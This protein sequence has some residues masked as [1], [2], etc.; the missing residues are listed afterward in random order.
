M[1]AA[2]RAVAAPMNAGLLMLR[3]RAGLQRSSRGAQG[4]TGGGEL[5]AR[6]QVAFDLYISRTLRSRHDDRRIRLANVRLVTRVGQR[7][8]RHK[9]DGR[10]HDDH[11]QRQALDQLS[12][13]SHAVRLLSLPTEG[14]CVMD[15]NIEQGRRSVMTCR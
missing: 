3:I 15:Y 6:D 2:R 8:C 5:G 11:C 12:Y 4:R 7:S 9:H 1:T 13:T 10:D 14:R